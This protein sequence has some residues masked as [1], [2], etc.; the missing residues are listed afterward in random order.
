MSLRSQRGNQDS[1]LSSMS[2]AQVGY[3]LINTDSTTKTIFSPRRQDRKEE[4]TS[5]VFY[6]A[7]F[8]PLREIPGRNEIHDS[9][10]KQK[11]PPQNRHGQESLP[12]TGR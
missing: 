1:W 5:G 10:K 3:G 12:A 8:A 2:P 6:L 4:G 7:L 11:K 9:R